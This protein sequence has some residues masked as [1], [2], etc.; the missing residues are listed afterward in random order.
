MHLTHCALELPIPAA[1]KLALVAFCDSADDR[2]RLAFPGLE[3]VMKTASVARTRAFELV[4]ELEDLG[5]LVKHRAGHRGRRAEYI[6]FPRGCCAA[7]PAPPVDDEDT[8]SDDQPKGSATADPNTP[9]EPSEKGSATADSMSGKGSATADPKSGVSKGSATADP[10]GVKGPERVRHSGPLLQQE[11]HTPQPPASGGRG[12]R[13]T[14]SKTCRHC[15]DTAALE[16]KKAAAAR[17]RE[18]DAAALAASRRAKAQTPAPN[19]ALLAA[20]RAAA[21]GGAR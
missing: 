15:R 17:Q 3:R 10:S 18:A 5:L 12:C 13:C 14:T 4:N 21:R 11:L 2:T 19:P 6:V 16:A 8:T 1:T 9:M 7:H 20:A